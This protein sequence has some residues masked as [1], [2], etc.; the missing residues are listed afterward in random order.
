M[1]QSADYIIIGGGTAGLVLANRLSENPD[2]QVLVLEAGNDLS[3]DPRVQIPALWQSLIGDPDT[4]W[5]F[6]SNPQPGLSNNR[7]TRQPQGKG[8]GGTSAI[9]GQVFVAP[10]RAEIDAWAELG[11]PGWDWDGLFPWL[12]KSFSL[13]PPE[14]RDTLEHLGIDWIDEECRGTEGPIKVSFPGTVDNQLNKAWIDAFRG[15]NKSTNA[16]PFTGTSIGGY[17]NTAS[18]DPETKTRSYSDTAYGIPARKRPNVKV[19][20]NAT[21]QAITFD[22]TTSHPIRA[23]GVRVLI[24][25]KDKTEESSF[26]AKREI[27]LSAGVYN[28]P[29]LLELSGIGNKS[30]LSH[31]D[32]PVRV[33]LPGVG[34]NLQDHLMT[35]MSYEVAPGVETID[36]LL[37]GEASSLASAQKLYEE[38]LS[39]P[40]TIGG[41]QSHAYMSTPYP[42]DLDALPGPLDPDEE[43]YYRT[44][45]SILENEDSSSGSWLMF[46]CQTKWHGGVRNLAKETLLPGN[47]ISLGCLQ[48]QTFSRG[49]THIRSADPGVP[50]EID[51]R[52]FSHPADLEIMARH[53]KALD[54]KLRTAPA[55]AKFLKPD[56]RRN[57]EDAFLVSEE[58]LEGAKKYLVDTAHGAF[59]GCG[60]AVMLPR[61][62]GGVVDTQL[63]VYGAENLRVVDASVFPVI[64][65]GN[66]ITVVYA[67]AEKAAGI[68]RGE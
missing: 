21:V 25:D 34:E 28:T 2:I 56:G 53:V 26:L 66:I 24:K 55:I 48:S 5:Q 8:L 23:T 17:S 6:H 29:K 12:K 30:I 31:H 51:P 7:P 49:W 27:I 9:N 19:I 57:H 50:P 39:G 11:N 41:M 46:L 65:R 18:V 13:F 4:D 60:T 10:G 61:G 42:L 1:T 14:D 63:R 33:H 68:I 44:I 64:P 3:S 67:V 37:R 45:R 62:K 59:H 38:N 22:D 32:I 52:Y 36:S 47:F 54:E 58:G 15:M 20:T 16:D 35:G 40:Y 43:E